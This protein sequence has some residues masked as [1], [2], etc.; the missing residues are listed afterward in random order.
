MDLMNHGDFLEEDLVKM[1]MI[2]MATNIAKGGGEGNL[3]DVFVRK[4]GGVVASVT[5][6]GAPWVHVKRRKSS[7]LNIPF[8]ANTLMIM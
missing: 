4:N 8:G 2:V 7:V 5:Q 3:G 1:T 6:I